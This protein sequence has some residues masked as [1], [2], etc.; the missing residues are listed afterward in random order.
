MVYL[1]TLQLEQPRY[2]NT[3][4]PIGWRARSRVHALSTLHLALYHRSGRKLRNS[5]F[6]CCNPFFTKY[7]SFS[8]SLVGGLYQLSLR[9]TYGNP[10]RSLYVQTIRYMA[11]RFSKPITR[12]LSTGR[13]EE[14]YGGAQTDLPKSYWESGEWI[15]S[16]DRSYYSILQGW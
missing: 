5:P 9:C 10:G 16:V 11:T 7:T 13:L 12:R 3:T 2:T 1:R 14:E 4:R 15:Q 6:F 8:S